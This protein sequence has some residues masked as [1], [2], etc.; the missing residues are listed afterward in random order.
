M[1]NSKLDTS[2][3]HLHLIL[4]EVNSI[5]VGL[6]RMPKGSPQL[7]LP[8][9]KYLIIR[10]CAFW[11]EVEKQFVKEAQK[12]SEYPQVE[13]IVEFLLKTRDGFF[14]DL[15]N[16]RNNVFA[17]NY[18][19]KLKN[20]SS[21]FDLETS[22]KFPRSAPELAVNIKL[23]DIFL[24]AM[25]YLYPNILNVYSEEIPSLGYVGTG[26]SDSNYTQIIQEIEN[27]VDSFL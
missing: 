19:V 25:K 16:I 8:I 17:H 18:R 24:A 20:Y 12:T 22:Y 6:D 7:Y 4:A 10:S 1:N 15:R 27:K 5:L 23:M 26:I 11:D 9:V 21:I 14:P 2:T 3:K 13:F